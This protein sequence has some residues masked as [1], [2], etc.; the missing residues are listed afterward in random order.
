[1]RQ[2]C[3]ISKELYFWE[4]ISNYYQIIIHKPFNNSEVN[5]DIIHWVNFNGTKNEI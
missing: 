1:M 2:A 5:S 4:K 3:R